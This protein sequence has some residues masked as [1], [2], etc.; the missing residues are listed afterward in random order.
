M[1]ILITGALG[2]LGKYAASR[3]CMANEVHAYDSK[4][5]DISNL[6]N[7]NAVLNE[8]KPDVVI[9]CAAYTKVD[10][11]ETE[12]ETAYLVNAIGPRNL[13]IAAEKTGAKLVHISTDYV[14][15]GDSPVPLRE[16]AP[17][18]PVTVYGKSKLMGEEFVRQ[19]SSKHFILRTAWLYG[20]GD[21]FAR[22]MLKLS[23]T[24]DRLRVV[25]DQY[26]SPTS[27]KD[28]SAAIESLISTEH[29]GTYHATCEGS[30]SWHNFAKKI[31]ELMGIDVEVEKV[32]S[33]EFIRPAKRPAYS[34]LDNFMLNLI[35]HNS[36]RRWE[37]ALEDYL[38]E[39][40]VWRNSN[41]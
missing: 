1:K 30:C 3:L 16:D 21:N 36:F 40:T 33:E 4:K 23:K 17:V 37:D 7:V 34:V 5:L 9:N 20:D 13:A 24:N 28:L 12:V 25:G 27:T 39:D 38:K 14:F 22:T 15:R 6:D 2:Q 18:G 41:L 19:F 8:V 31:F 10:L 35:G 32:T 29:Y 11:C 26:G